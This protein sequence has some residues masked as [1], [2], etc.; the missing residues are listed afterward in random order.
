MVYYRTGRWTF[1]HD[2][3]RYV[4]VNSNLDRKLDD[5]VSHST[6]CGVIPLHI[7]Y[8]IYHIS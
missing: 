4:G 1:V 2:I 8:I 3:L 6:I 7:S 5:V